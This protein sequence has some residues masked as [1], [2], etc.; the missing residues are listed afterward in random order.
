[1]IKL[2]R[3]VFRERTAKRSRQL[4]VSAELKKEMRKNAVAA[5]GLAATLSKMSSDI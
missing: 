3:K 2:V 4:E 1:M 5:D